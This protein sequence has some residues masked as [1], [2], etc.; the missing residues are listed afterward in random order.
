MPM[1]YQ[2]AVTL[3]VSSFA[4][5]VA[6]TV[7]LVV[8]LA[9]AGVLV[10]AKD[11]SKRMHRFDPTPGSPGKGMKRLAGRFLSRRANTV[12]CIGFL[13]LLCTMLRVGMFNTSRA[14]TGGVVPAADSWLEELRARS[15]RGSS[16]M[17]SH[18]ATAFK[19]DYH[20]RA[21]HAGAGDRGQPNMPVD[22]QRAPHRAGI[23]A[24]AADATERRVTQIRLAQLPSMTDAEK[25]IMSDAQ[26]ELSNAASALVT[27]GSLRRGEVSSQQHD[28][29]TRF[30]ACCH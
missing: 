24:E 1:T 8:L 29:A 17:K 2:T 18:M 12:A 16:I 9:V 10:T 14:H 15:A 19:G 13:L 7:L 25:R 26:L 27:R 5:V 23:V 21:A 28:T 6:A 11:A 22:S 30:E 4:H 20:D 3:F